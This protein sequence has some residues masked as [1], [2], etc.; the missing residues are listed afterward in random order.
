MAKKENKRGSQAKDIHAVRFDER[1]WM[2]LNEVAEIYN[3][4]VS[5]VIRTLLNK[6]L[7]DITDEAGYIQRGN[8]YMKESG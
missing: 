6:V 8:K 4:G 5:V 2:R 3:T 7:D 1:T